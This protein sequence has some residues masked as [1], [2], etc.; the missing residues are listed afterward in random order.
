[1]YLLGGEV[2]QELA[3]VVAV[4]ALP[5]VACPGDAVGPA[6]GAVCDEAL[7]NG[8]QHLHRLSSG[9]L[10]STLHEFRISAK[11]SHQEPS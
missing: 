6:V 7:V 11:T 8:L 1:M 4:L 2:V 5:V 9:E 3:D 10:Q